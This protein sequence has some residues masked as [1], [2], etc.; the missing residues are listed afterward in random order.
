MDEK[1]MIIAVNNMINEKLD[2]HCRRKLWLKNSGKK[3]RYKIAYKDSCELCAYY[4]NL[5]EA[6]NRK[7]EKSGDM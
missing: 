2:F 6:F 7:I 4:T 5:K 1:T 3:E